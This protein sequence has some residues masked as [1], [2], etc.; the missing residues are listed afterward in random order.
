L[1]QRNK[2][3][4][5]QASK[6]GRIRRQIA[7]KEKEKRKPKMRQIGRIRHQIAGKAKRGRKIENET[8]PEKKGRPPQ[9]DGRRME[10]PL[11]NKIQKK[12]GEG[13]KGLIQQAEKNKDEHR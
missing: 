9:P 6:H 5:L 13:G 3:A 12:L 8:D 11:V 10:S 4:D 1:K 7:G 2:N